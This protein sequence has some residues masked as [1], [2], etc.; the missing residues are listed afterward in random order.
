MKAGQ[1]YGRL[2]A[3][4]KA[5]RPGYWVFS[6]E[7]G[8]EK[9]IRANTVSWEKGVRSCGCLQKES[10][11]EFLTTHGGSYTASYASWRKMRSR[12]LNENDRHYDNYGGRGIK[13]CKRWM[14]FENFWKDMGNRP[15]GMSIDRID[16]DG[17][18]I[19]DNCRWATKRLQQNNRKANHY[20]EIDGVKQSLSDWARE[21]G[22]STQTI[23]WRLRS[24]W[25]E[26]EAILVPTQ[27]HIRSTLK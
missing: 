26:R 24:G 25:S 21:K 4:K 27:K 14:K 1:K 18:Y 19:P 16:R 9:E 20:I 5:E 10:A 6:C 13:I 11:K 2:T 17:D 3:I 8:T 15:Q 22:M 7:C 23:H 12:C